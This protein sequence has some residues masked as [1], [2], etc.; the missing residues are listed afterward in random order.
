M[1]LLQVV[2]KDYVDVTRNFVRLMERNSALTRHHLFLMCM[3]DESLEFFETSMGIRC[4]PMSAFDL[5]THQDIWKLRYVELLCCLRVFTCALIR[6]Y[7]RRTYQRSVG[8]AGVVLPFHFLS[9][10]T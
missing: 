1:A 6:L 5:P 4:V 10:S 8:P 2:S 3:D 9:T 7:G